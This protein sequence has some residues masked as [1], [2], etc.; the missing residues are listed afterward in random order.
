MAETAF[1]CPLLSMGHKTTSGNP[2][3]VSCIR[4]KCMW[5]MLSYNSMCA[6]HMFAIE[7]KYIS[8]H[9]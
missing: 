4:E 1:I 9:V 2:D 3:F 7:T 6:I 5:Y 8:D